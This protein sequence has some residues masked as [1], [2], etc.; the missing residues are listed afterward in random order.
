MY[1]FCGQLY[2]IVFVPNTPLHKAM[3]IIRIMTNFM[4]KQFFL[5]ILPYFLFCLLFSEMT[6]NIFLIV[7]T[8]IFCLA[9]SILLFCVGDASLPFSY[10]YIAP[11][12]NTRSHYRICSLPD[13]GVRSWDTDPLE[14][15][16]PNLAGPSMSPCCSLAAPLLLPCLDS[17]RKATPW[18][19]LDSLL[20]YLRPLL[21][22]WT[23][24]NF[25]LLSAY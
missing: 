24:Q 14:L 1:V 4:A 23:I 17:Y 7:E 5:R 16:P 8:A 18:K 10:I 19:H 9:R 6:W 21:C 12:S 3:I 20:I 25:E 13:A 11:F 2:T 15:T 22:Q